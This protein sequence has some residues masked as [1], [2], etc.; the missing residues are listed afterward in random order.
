[1]TNDKKPKEQAPEPVK[2]SNGTGF[3]VDWS[4]KSE[5]DKTSGKR[6]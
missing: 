4:K 3:G 5:D 2:Q 6:G 1:M